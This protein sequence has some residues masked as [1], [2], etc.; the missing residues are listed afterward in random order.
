VDPLLPVDGA[1]PV[2]RPEPDPA[3]LR[4]AAAP[5]DLA[6]RWHER[7]DAVVRVTAAGPGRAGVAERA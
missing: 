4:A 6:R 1:I 3:L 7:R 5:D 2:R